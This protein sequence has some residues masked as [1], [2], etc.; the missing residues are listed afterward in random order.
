VYLDS[1]PKSFLRCAFVALCACVGGCFYE[2]CRHLYKHK[3]LLCSCVAAR[4]TS[5][6]LLQCCCW[7]VVFYRLRREQLKLSVALSVARLYKGK[8]L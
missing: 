6:V 1:T 7:E 4:G 5:A 3:G 8:K 2:M